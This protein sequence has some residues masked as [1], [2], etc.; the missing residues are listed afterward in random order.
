MRDDREPIYGDLRGVR[1]AQARERMLRP[2]IVA[3]V[4]LSAAC[5]ALLVAWLG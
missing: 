5:L 1:E 4:L 3:I 2:Y